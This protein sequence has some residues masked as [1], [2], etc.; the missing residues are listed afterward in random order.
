MCMSALSKYLGSPC[1]SGHFIS[2][3]HNKAWPL[4]S[5]YS[6]HP[7]NRTGQTDRQTDRQ[8][9]ETLRENEYY[10][11]EITFV[12]DIIFSTLRT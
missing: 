2:S 4:S 9:G 5:T 12:G 6:G 7:S 11:R 1:T 10:I 3:G 8:C